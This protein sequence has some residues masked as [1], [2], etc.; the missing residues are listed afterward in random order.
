MLLFKR[1]SKLEKTLSASDWLI[2]GN[3]NKELLV[4]AGV[5]ISSSVNDTSPDYQGSIPTE[6]NVDAWR[7]FT[8]PINPVKG[9]E[10]SGAIQLAFGLNRPG[11]TDGYY[12]DN[13]KLEPK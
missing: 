1:I 9:A 7:T 6:E 11:G 4:L 5:E 10:L 12:F 3:F 13:L 2:S 8:L